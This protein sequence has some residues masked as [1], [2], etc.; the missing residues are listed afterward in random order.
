M[1]RN[2][3]LNEGSNETRIARELLKV[4]KMLVAGNGDEESTGDDKEEAEK[5]KELFNPSEFKEVGNEIA[6]G[7]NEIG[8]SAKDFANDVKELDEKGAS[9]KLY[10]ENYSFVA[11]YLGDIK[12]ANANEKQVKD[13]YAINLAAHNLYLKAAKLKKECQRYARLKLAH[14]VLVAESLGDL[15]PQTVKDSAN[16]IIDIAKGIHDGIQSV[17]NGLNRFM[18][19]VKE[20]AAK[21]GKTIGKFTIGVIIG[22]LWIG[23]KVASGA[24]KL[25]VAGVNKIIAVSK[26]VGGAIGEKADEVAEV[27]G[28]EL[29]KISNAMDTAWENI[30]DAVRS[31]AES[32]EK[33]VQTII[34]IVNELISV[35]VGVGKGLARV[36]SGNLQHF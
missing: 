11:K 33:G 30:K 22:A 29:E 21:L 6:Q 7:M 27:V 31:M 32:V 25:A 15:D 18:D 10:R 12:I 13:F 35:V 16:F 24:W 8:E 28:T 17:V 14:K 34:H 5:A 23:W 2:Y 9:S 19:L 26:K 36:F 1:R 4:A 3:Y 20:K